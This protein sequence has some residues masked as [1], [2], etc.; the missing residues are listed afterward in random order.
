VGAHPYLTLGRPVDELLLRVPARTVLESDG[1]GL[2]RGARPVEGSE[3]DFRQPRTIGAT[4]LDHCF[5]DVE[6]DDD[7][8]ARVV[9]EDPDRGASVTLWVDRTHPYLMV[10]TGDPL[11]DVA[12]RAI[13]VEPM[14]CPPNALAT[15]TSVITLAPGDSAS[16]SWG[17]TPG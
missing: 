2:P 3:Y 9:L 17:I 4:V 1:R 15:N 14:T 11:A 6:L 8:I 13:A 16:G 5:T 12:R 7:G 10:F